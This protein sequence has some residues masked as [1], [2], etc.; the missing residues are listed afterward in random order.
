MI[1]IVAFSRR[2]VLFIR[3]GNNNDKNYTIQYKIFKKSENSFEILI[4]HVGV[5][6]LDLFYYEHVLQS[7][8]V[9]SEI[10]SGIYSFL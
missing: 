6:T 3:K 5:Y 1:I 8:V 7:K 10:E 4:R 2:H 9:L